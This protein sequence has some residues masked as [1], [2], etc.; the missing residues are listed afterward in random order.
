[1]PIFVLNLTRDKDTKPFRAVCSILGDGAGFN[2]GLRHFADDLEV[3]Q[4]LNSAGIQAE[5]YAFALSQ[6]LSGGQGSMDIDQNE[7]QKLGVL[8]TDSSE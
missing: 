2:G 3:V 5:R 1:M 6:V 8:Q 7:A 4:A